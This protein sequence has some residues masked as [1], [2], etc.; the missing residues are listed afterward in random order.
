AEIFLDPVEEKSVEFYQGIWKELKEGK[1]KDIG[2]RYYFVIVK[3]DPNKEALS[4]SAIWGIYCARKQGRE[5]AYLDAWF[6]EAH[7]PNFP[8]VDSV[9]KKA[10]LNYREFTL[11]R[12]NEEAFRE[13]MQNELIAV[14]E[15]EIQVVPSVLFSGTLLDGLREKKEYDEILDRL[16]SPPKEDEWILWE[17]EEPECTLC[18]SEGTK[19]QLQANL[20]MPARVIRLPW[21][22]VTQSPTPPALRIP[23][24]FSNN[25]FEK[26]RAVTQL[27]KIFKPVGKYWEVPPMSSGV[28]KIYGNQEKIPVRHAMGKEDAPLTVYEFTNFHCPACRMFALQLLPVIKSEYIESGKVRWEVIHFPLT[29]GEQDAINAAIASECA[30]EQNSFW[31]Y[32]D[33]LFMN[34]QNL[35]RSDLLR[36]AG[37]VPQIKVETFTSCLNTRKPASL[38]ENDIRLSEKLGVSA[39]PTFLAGSYL[40]SNL[41][42]PR[43][44]KI[45]DEEI[46]RR[47]KSSP[48]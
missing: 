8:P 43:L 9:A 38:V 16:K 45:F 48:Q 28:W 22:E 1:A 25:G 44:K 17:L 36:Y 35:S 42:Y 11:C 23:A 47:S 40:F 6:S 21:R 7:P 26:H 30:A 34:Q 14:V 4:R 18:G 19:V 32:H 27:K 33:I 3:A 46:A 10:R 24:L 29:G 20:K 37:N 39:T 12:K 41:P 5:E 15:K 2:R 31:P 13:D